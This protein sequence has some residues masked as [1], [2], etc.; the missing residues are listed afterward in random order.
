MK[1]NYYLAVSSEDKDAH[2]L[3]IPC[4]SISRYIPQRKSAHKYKD[5]EYI[6]FVILTSQKQP[7]CP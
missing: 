7:K 5:A 1:Y 3:S 6:L 4:H 2:T